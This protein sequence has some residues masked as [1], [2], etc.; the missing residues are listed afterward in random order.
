MEKVKTNLQITLGETEEGK[1]IKYDLW[2]LKN[3]LVVGNVGAGKTIFLQET[4]LNLFKKK[5]PSNVRVVIFDPKEV[6]YPDFDKLPNCEVVTGLKKAKHLLELYYGK[7]KIGECRAS[8][9]K[10]FYDNYILTPKVTLLFV[11]ELADYV[12]SGSEMEEC[13]CEIFQNGYTAGIFPVFATHNL[14]YMPE[15]IQDCFNSIVALQY[16]SNFLLPEKEKKQVAKIDNFGSLFYRK[17]NESVKLK[18]VDLNSILCINKM[19]ARN[20]RQL[21]FW[22]DFDILKDKR[23]QEMVELAIKQGTIC[24]T[25]IRRKLDCGY[26]L[27]ARFVD[28]MEYLGFISPAKGA[29]SRDVYITKREFEEILKQLDLK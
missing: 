8:E 24:A 22:Q 28:Y 12:L 14:K 1:V 7:V 23:F 19:I 3:L 10:K 21:M 15:R 20:K 25:E 6:E 9:G 26:P 18:P 2:K 4:I 17:D 29:F 16:D 11:D 13:M 27:A 5:L